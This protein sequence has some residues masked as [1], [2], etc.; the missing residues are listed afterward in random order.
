MSFSATWMDLQ[1]IILS[2]V[3]QTNFMDHLYLESKTMIQMKLFGKLQINGNKLTDFEN[4]I[5]V[6]KG[7]R[8]QG[9]GWIGGLGLAHAQ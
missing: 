3:S 9:E 2:E 4:K 5:M 8:W 1:I 6:T 7:E